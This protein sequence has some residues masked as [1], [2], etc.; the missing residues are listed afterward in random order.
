MSLRGLPRARGARRHRPG[1]DGP[2]LLVAAAGE[3]R[4]QAWIEQDLAAPEPIRKTSAAS[5]LAALGRREDARAA[6]VELRKQAPKERMLER[7][8]RHRGPASPIAESVL[9]ETGTPYR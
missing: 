4:V 7:V 2:A 1:R 3:L 8:V 5:A 9:A 6:L